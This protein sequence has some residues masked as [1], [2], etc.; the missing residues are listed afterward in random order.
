VEVGDLD[1]MILNQILNELQ[2]LKRDVN[3]LKSDVND[4]KLDMGE[5]RDKLVDMDLTLAGVVAHQIEDYGLLR[6]V[7]AKVTLLANLSQVHE[8]KFEKLR[9]I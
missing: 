3:D 2:G 8:Q 6:E 9:L 4:L 1:N 5:V 7:D